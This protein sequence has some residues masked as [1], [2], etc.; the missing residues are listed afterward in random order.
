MKTVRAALFGAMLAAGVGSATAAF[1]ADPDFCRDYARSAIAQYH[2][3]ESHGRCRD[4]ITDYNVW[5]DNWQHHY[6]WCLG[7][8]RDQAWAGRRQRED[9]LDACR[10]HHQDDWR[11]DDRRPY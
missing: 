2:E 3:A 9:F 5:S 10:E 7:V 6:G 11:R 8:S 4:R 1:S